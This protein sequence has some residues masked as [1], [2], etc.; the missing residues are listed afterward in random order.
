MS[1]RK[2]GS[3]INFEQRNPD[4]PTVHFSVT[5]ISTSAESAGHFTSIQSTGK[6]VGVNDTVKVSH[7]SLPDSSARDQA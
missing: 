2:N 3:W 1:R 7:Q 5:C 4:A 6:I